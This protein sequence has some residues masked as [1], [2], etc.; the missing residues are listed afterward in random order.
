MLAGITILNIE[1][2]KS[3]IDYLVVYILSSF[4]IWFIIMHLTKK[5]R[6]LINLKGLSLN[7]S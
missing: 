4:I 2:A 6:T 7:N 1:G 5:T 3:S